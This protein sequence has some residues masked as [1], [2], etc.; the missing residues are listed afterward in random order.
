MDSAYFEAHGLFLTVKEGYARTRKQRK[1]I[2]LLHDL[3]GDESYKKLQ[4]LTEGKKD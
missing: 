1:S 3:K 2:Q 4:R